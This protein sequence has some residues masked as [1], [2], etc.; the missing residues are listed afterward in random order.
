[1]K[2][3]LRI[4]YIMTCCFIACQ[5]QPE[6]DKTSVRSIMYDIDTNKV[7]IVKL[8]R[9]ET[10]DFSVEEAK[11]SK[12]AIYD[13]QLSRKYPE[14]GSPGSIIHINGEDKIEVYQFV[15]ER[16]NNKNGGSV[17]ITKDDEIEVYQFSFDL[18]TYMKINENGD[19]VPA[20]KLVEHEAPMI[21]KKENL[22]EYVEATYVG[23]IADV[24]ITS[25]YDLKQS[26]SLD[27]ILEELFEPYTQIYYLKKK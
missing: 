18:D 3:F 7:Q 17:H 27:F 20:I 15:L 8:H 5:N 23:E 12:Q 10:E 14:W 24:L 25:E 11:K 13:M 26:K 6:N 16:D 9:P 21:V 2:V 19:S 4:I 1:M 22:K